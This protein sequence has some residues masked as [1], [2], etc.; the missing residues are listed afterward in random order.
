VSI[1]RWYV[2]ECA[3]WLVTGLPFQWFFTGFNGLSFF[4]MPDAPGS[5]GPSLAAWLLA[6]TF[7]YH[8]ALLAPV[9]IWSA[10]SRRKP[11]GRKRD[12]EQG[13]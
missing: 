13:T 8:P 5:G 2:W 3:I 10:F 4:S 11:R 1:P 12:H 7:L 6:L 9:A